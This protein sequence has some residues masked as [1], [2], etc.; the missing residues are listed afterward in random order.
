MRPLLGGLRI[1]EHQPLR[2]RLAPPD[3]VPVWARVDRGDVET[4]LRQRASRNDERGS[5]DQDD[6]DDAS[7]CSFVSGV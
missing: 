4:S 5:A 6:D 1:R 3:I 2:T 7:R